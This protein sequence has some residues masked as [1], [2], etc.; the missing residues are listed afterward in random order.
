MPRRH[1]RTAP[2]SETNGT[3]RDYGSRIGTKVY[4]PH[5]N[6][7]GLHT[8]EPTTECPSPGIDSETLAFV[9]R[10]AHINWTLVPYGDDVE[11]GGYD[12]ETATWTGTLGHGL[13]DTLD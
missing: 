10:L 2:H 12:K 1:Q 4:K 6:L 11:W 9:L 3:F 7:C 13:L 8:L 5:V